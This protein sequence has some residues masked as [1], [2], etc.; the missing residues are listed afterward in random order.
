MTR[1][2]PPVLFALLGLALVPLNWFHPDTLVMRADAAM[3]WDVPLALG[4][5]VL[6]WAFVHF[7]R[8][9]A[10]IHTFKQPKDIITDGPF[11][12][13]R[14]PMYLGFSLLL[15][16]AAFYVNTWSALLAPLAFVLTAMFWYIPHEERRMRE[17]FGT[18]YDEYAGKTRRW[19]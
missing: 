2:V 12:Y 6:L 16:G 15:L 17:T 10:E 11:R 8:K 4:L 1:L 19:I 9:R 14:N 7:K 5:A 18:A 3:P 13:S